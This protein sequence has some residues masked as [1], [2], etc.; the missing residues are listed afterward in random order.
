LEGPHGYEA[1]EKF[2][3]ELSNV[4]ATLPGKDPLVYPVFKDFLNMKPLIVA[5]LGLPAGT[6]TPL[7]ESAIA[8][9]IEHIARNLPLRSTNSRSGVAA[10]ARST[11]HGFR[12]Q[13]PLALTMQPLGAPAP[14]RQ[15]FLDLALMNAPHMPVARPDQSTLALMNAPAASPQLP[16]AAPQLLEASQQPP[17][18]AAATAAAA[19]AAADSQKSD[20]SAQQPQQQQPAL[21]QTQTPQEPALTQTQTPQ[22]LALTQTQTPPK[23]VAQMVGALANL[24]KKPAA[25]VIR[26]TKKRSGGTKSGGGNDTSPPGVEATTYIVSYSPLQ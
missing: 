16:P 24:R 26:T 4:P 12:S 2:R 13:A 17:A 22:K 25:A 7:F 8:D 23:T 1:I 5:A 3:M 10:V 9:K 15:P 21:T 18:A 14:T 20:T 6:D 11:R 19:A